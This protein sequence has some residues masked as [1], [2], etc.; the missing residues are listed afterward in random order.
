MAEHVILP[1]TGN[2]DVTTQVAVDSTPDGVIQLFKLVVS[3]DGQSVLVPADLDGVFVQSIQRAEN[4]QDDLLVQANLAAGSNIDLDA[5]AITI[6]KMG[7]LMGVDAGASVPLR[8]D[9]QLV[10]GSRVTRTSLYT[11]AGG[12]LSWRPPAPTFVELIG[13]GT[14]KFGVSITNLS[15]SRAADVSATVY[16]D[17]VTP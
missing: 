2:G 4:P 15:P 3:A 17:E 16:W 13:A 9:I 1:L 7:R 11:M 8:V 14:N 5:T 10:S 6:G 12:F